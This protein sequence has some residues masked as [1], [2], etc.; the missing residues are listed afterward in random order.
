MR[1]LYRLYAAWLC[2]RYGYAPI[3]Y[4]KYTTICLSD[5]SLLLTS[6]DSEESLD[7]ALWALDRPPH[8]WRATSLGIDVYKKSQEDMERAEST[9][10]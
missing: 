9:A 1:Y 3:P 5:H 7:V 8:Y 2:I 6:K 10:Q 4:T